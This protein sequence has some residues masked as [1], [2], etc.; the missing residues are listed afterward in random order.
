M[1]IDTCPIA[2]HGEFSREEGCPSCAISTDLYDQLVAAGVPV[3]SHESDLY[4]KVTPE[5][6][7]I[8]AAAREAG[9]LH[10]RPSTFYNEQQPKGQRELWYDIP[11]MYSPFWRK[12][13]SR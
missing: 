13:A 3:D 9:R 1:S 8:I 11:F 6:T 10:T 2:N 7:A 12:R 5:S 4:A